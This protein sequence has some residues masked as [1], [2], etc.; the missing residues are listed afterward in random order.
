MRGGID[1]H[2]YRSGPAPAGDD[3]AAGATVWSLYIERLNSVA[4]VGF[5]FAD[6]RNPIARCL[7][8]I[9][10]TD[11]VYR[12]SECWIVSG[13]AFVLIARQVIEERRNARFRSVEDF[14]ESSA[15]LSG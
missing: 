12:P 3:E 8:N 7:L 11:S 14:Q 4:H 2:R 5:S 6:T 15:N 10:Q 13:T 9:E 1:R